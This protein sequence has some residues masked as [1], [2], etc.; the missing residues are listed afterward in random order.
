VWAAE[1]DGDTVTNEGGSE[2]AVKSPRKRQE[3]RWR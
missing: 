1:A 3:W 2:M